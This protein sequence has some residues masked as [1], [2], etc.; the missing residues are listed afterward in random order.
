MSSL[1]FIVGFGLGIY[2]ATYYNCKPIIEK[3]RKTIEDNIPPEKKNN[4]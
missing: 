1:K 3:I 2:V 4:T